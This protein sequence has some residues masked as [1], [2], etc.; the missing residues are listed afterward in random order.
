MISENRTLPWSYVKFTFYI[1]CDASSPHFVR[2]F[3][4]M[5]TFAGTFHKDHHFCFFSYFILFYVSFLFKG[6][7]DLTTVSEIGIVIVHFVYFKNKNR[8]FVT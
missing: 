3:E 4:L 8:N 7:T 1:Y 2:K 5:E 6:Q